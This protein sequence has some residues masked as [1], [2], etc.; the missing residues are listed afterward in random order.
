MD[1][2]FFDNWN[3]LFRTAVPQR[4]HVP[5]ETVWLLAPRRL[6]RSDLRFDLDVERLE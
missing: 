5:G 6:R 3:A 1:T 2:I 4:V